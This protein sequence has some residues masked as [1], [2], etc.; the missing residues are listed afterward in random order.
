MVNLLR[1]GVLLGLLAILSASTGGCG[2]FAAASAIGAQLEREKKIEVL[3]EYDGLLNHSV[4]VVVQ[5]DPSM[6]Y[7][8]PTVTANVCA[9]LSARIATNVQGAQ[10]LDP[11]I[12]LQW[13]YQ[14]PHWASLPYGQ[15]AADLGVDRVVLV[16]I[17]EYRLNPPG[18]TWMWDGVCAATVGVIEGNSADADEFAFSKNVTVKFPDEEGISRE[19]ATARQV[20][21]GLLTKFLQRTAWLFFDHIED[22]YPDD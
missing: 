14:T 18:N 6:L 7:E 16:D 10:V 15:I 2:V 11:R 5:S 19:Q 9:N 4:A 12:V 21:T 3:A 22:K 1:R 8:H 20:E 17:F 13:Q